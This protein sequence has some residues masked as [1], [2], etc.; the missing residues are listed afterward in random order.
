MINAIL[1]YRSGTELRLW[2]FCGTISVCGTEVELG[3]LHAGHSGEGTVTLCD[4]TGPSLHRPCPAT[5]HQPR[6]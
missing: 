4:G 2:F 3:E 1:W 5:Q 6:T